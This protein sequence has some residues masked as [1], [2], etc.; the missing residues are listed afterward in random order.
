M[1][2]RKFSGAVQ[3]W[4]SQEK[5]SPPQNC[6]K[7]KVSAP[8]RPSQSSKAGKHEASG[9]ARSERKWIAPAIP[10]GKKHT[11][12]LVSESLLGKRRDHCFVT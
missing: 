12:L 10:V 7:E 5:V 1:H 6:L 3:C 8:R 2:L 4:K 9:W 11:K